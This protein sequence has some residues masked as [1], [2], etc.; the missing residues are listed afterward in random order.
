LPIPRALTEEETSQYDNGGSVA[1]DSD[2]ENFRESSSE[3]ASISHSKHLLQFLEG[4]WS[5]LMRRVKIVS[6]NLDYSHWTT[7]NVAG[8]GYQGI[9]DTGACGDVFQVT[10]TY[11]GLTLLDA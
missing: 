7:D 8:I 3:D 2:D 10:P 1:S 4:R 9:I 6:G 5:E 11:F